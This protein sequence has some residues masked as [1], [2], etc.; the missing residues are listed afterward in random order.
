[1]WN[2]VSRATIWTCVRRKFCGNRSKESD[3][4]GAS[5][6]SQKNNASMTHFSHS[7]P[8][9]D[10]AGNVQGSLFRS[11]PHLPSF[12]QIHSSFRDLL[13]KTT[14][15]IVTIIGDPIGY[16]IA[17]NDEQWWQLD[18]IIDD[19]IHAVADPP[20]LQLYQPI[21]CYLCYDIIDWKRCTVYQFV[22]VLSCDV[23]LFSCTALFVSIS[24][25]IG[26]EDCLR[27]DLLCVGWGVKLYSLTHCCRVPTWFSANQ[28][29]LLYHYSYIRSLWSFCTIWRCIQVCFLSSSCVDWFPKLVCVQ[30]CQA[31]R[32]KRSRI[33]RKWNWK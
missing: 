24:Q 23:V 13:A 1:M 2:R 31:R 7:V 22:I 30:Q 5:F 32:R 10:F 8:S 28:P 3:R 11:Q 9:C 14:F 17:D 6:M 33:S 16:R 29:L 20:D 19:I 26:C 25:V 4:S 12:I 21:N 27:N 18:N 15:Q